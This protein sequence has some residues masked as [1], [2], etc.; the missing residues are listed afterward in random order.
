MY[1]RHRI[2][3]PKYDDMSPGFQNWMLEQ[4]DAAIEVLATEQLEAEGY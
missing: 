1:E 2:A 4:A 3:S